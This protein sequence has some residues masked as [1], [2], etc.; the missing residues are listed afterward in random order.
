MAE[1]DAEEEEEVIS[2]APIPKKEP[3]KKSK[4]VVLFEE[5]KGKFESKVGKLK[6]FFS[7]PTRGMEKKSRKNLEI[8]TFRKPTDGGTSDKKNPLFRAYSVITPEFHQT[9][10][11]RSNSLSTCDPQREALSRYY[12]KR[13]FISMDS[14]ESIQSSIQTSLQKSHSNLFQQTDQSQ[15]NQDLS[16]PPLSPYSPGGRKASLS[17][18]RSSLSALNLSLHTSTKP[19]RIRFN[20]TP[21]IVEITETHYPSPP[22][23]KQY[24][25][26]GFK[27]DPKTCLADEHKYIL[28]FYFFDFIFYFYF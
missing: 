11:R 23:S 8:Q 18:S 20:E 25:L 2:E 28:F 13:N 19:I 26:P 1:K 15:Q 9:D 4:K 22:E 21:E 10:L 12:G 16:S 14:V 7:H 6:E 27:S 3:V 5:P 17:S 24:P